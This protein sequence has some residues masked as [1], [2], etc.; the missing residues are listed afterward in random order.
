[1]M[2]TYTEV[3]DGIKINE[4]WLPAA[5]YFAATGTGFLPNDA[6]LVPRSATLDP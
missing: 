4:S 3:E 5:S 1:M 6:S 2:G